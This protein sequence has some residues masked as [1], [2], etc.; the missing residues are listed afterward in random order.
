MNRETLREYIRKNIHFTIGSL[1]NLYSSYLQHKE[2]SKEELEKIITEIKNQAIEINTSLYNHT[3]PKDS[4]PELEEKL[5]EKIEKEQKERKIGRYYASE[6]YSYF[7]N[8]I[9]P[10]KYLEP[11]VHSLDEL[12]RMY[13]GEIIHLGI[14]NL[15]DFKE[16][17]YEIKIE[18]DITLV[19]KID[20]EL[21]NGEIIE[22]KTREDLELDFLPI[23]WNYQL[24]AYLRAKKLERM[25]IYVVGWGL[26]RREFVVRQDEKVWQYI[27][28]NLK[29]YHNKVLEIY[30]KNRN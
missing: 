18:P 19:C 7:T 15:F 23:W 4:F 10:E 26:S 12:Q 22:L 29:N 14:Q 11:Q 9:P 30:S 1:S 16:K 6:L 20:L 25:R 8:K 24:Q 5:K 13:F 3:A 17:K 27:V 21:P 2:I 28:Q